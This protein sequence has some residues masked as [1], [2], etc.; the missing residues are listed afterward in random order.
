MAGTEVAAIPKKE[1]LISDDSELRKPAVYIA[2][3]VPDWVAD[4]RK[5]QAGQHPRWNLT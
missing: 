1:G 3:G 5:E 2:G 4:C